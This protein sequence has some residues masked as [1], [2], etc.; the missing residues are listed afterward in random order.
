MAT[1][2]SNSP[3][4][5][6]GPYLDGTAYIGIATSETVIGAAQ[7]SIG[8]MYRRPGDG[9]PI[10]GEF[11]KGAEAR[12]YFAREV[13]ASSHSWILYLDGDMLYPPNLLERLR[14]HG[15]PCVSG[16]YVR[17][18]EGLILPIWYEDDP[19]FH[20]PM[21]PFR[22]TPQQGRMYRLGATGFGCWLIHRCVFEAVEPL[23]KGEAFVWQDDMDVWPYDLKEVLAGREQLRM[24][25]GTKDQVGAD[26]RLSY[27][28]RRAG[29]PI[30]GDPDAF[31]GH[32]IQYPLSLT[33]WKGYPSD[34]REAF[35]RGTEYE[36]ED[37]R[38]I[39]EAEKA[40]I[41]G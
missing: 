13:L 32:Y 34:F 37:I 39:R 1:I 4:D 36:L 18:K 16:H 26:V 22:G 28:I 9:N 35:A 33:D 17:R 25:K 2:Y 19:E 40:E 31:C 3:L 5:T 41:V 10:F 24:L 38:A 7:R 8:A 27:F 11:T 29:F 14:C 30:W 20:W 12:E 21:M 15:L 6:P 23:L